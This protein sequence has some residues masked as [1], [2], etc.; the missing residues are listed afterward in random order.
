MKR[1][2]TYQGLISVIIST[3]NWH[4]ALHLSLSSLQNQSDKNFEVIIVDDGSGNDTKNMI[5][6][7]RKQAN[8]PLKHLWQ[9]DCGF[10][11]ARARNLGIQAAEGEYIVLIDGDCV[12]QTG[13]I[14]NHRKL[15]KSGCFVPGHRVL[16][17]ERYTHQ[18]LECG[19][20]L[21]KK[22]VFYW[23][24]Q[25]I[26]RNCNRWF[27]KLHLTLWYRQGKA[28]KWQGA[29][30]CNVGFWKKD[31]IT[32]KGFDEE[33][34]GWGSEDSDIMVRIMNSGITRKSGKFATEIFHLWHPKADRTLRDRNFDL[35]Q[36]TLKEKRIEPAESIFK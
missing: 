3:Y 11:V 33:F 27:P 20:E 7:F 30:T 2:N 10:R 5:E 22:S 9:E 25:R 1:E 34:E 23:L 26:K 16:L 19:I 14:A 36:Q 4:Q 31:L 24:Y 15:A 28:N 32:I 6:E 17:F 29:K 18:V 21:W 35:F 12:T 13:F 8:F